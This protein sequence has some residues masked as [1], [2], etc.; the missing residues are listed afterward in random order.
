MSNG[1]NTKRF[2]SSLNTDL[3]RIS[4]VWKSIFKFVIHIQKKREE[5]NKVIWLLREQK[6]PNWKMFCCKKIPEKLSQLQ[7]G[8]LF[9]CKLIRLVKS[10]FYFL[11]WFLLVSFNS[12]AFAF[13]CSLRNNF[14]M[15]PSVLKDKL[16]RMLLYH[17][18]RS[19]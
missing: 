3:D 11:A 1:K 10:P 6:L 12:N 16:G 2:D 4:S 8:H 7:S 18:P 15:W 5:K 17:P 13:F 9:F 14:L 19:V